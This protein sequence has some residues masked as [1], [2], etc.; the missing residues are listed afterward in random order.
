MSDEQKRPPTGAGRFRRES[1]RKYLYLVISTL[2]FVGGGLI[3][4]IYGPE[5]LFTAAPCLLGGA[6]LILLPWLLLTAVERWRRRMEQ[7]DRD[8]LG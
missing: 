2:V 8:A 1:D 3:A 4:L 6:L 7:A 5:A